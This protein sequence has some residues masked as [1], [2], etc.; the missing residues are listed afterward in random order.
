MTP[1]SERSTLALSQDRRDLVLGNGLVRR[2]IRLSP[3]ATTVS[4]DDLR[5]DRAH[6]RATGA[7]A[8]LRVD[9]V[10]HAVGGLTGQPDRAYLR[11]EW[12][13]QSRPIDGALQFVHWRAVPVEAP[14]SWKRTAGDAE[15]PWPPRGAGMALSFRTPPGAST[16][17][18]VDVHHEI[19]DGIPVLGKWLVVRNTGTRAMRIDGFS[20][21]RL[22]IAE[23]ESIVDHTD[24]WRDPDIVVHSD[25]MFAGK[26]PGNANKVAAWEVDP[27]YQTQVHYERRTPCILHVRPPMGPGVVLAP[28][29]SLRSFRSHLCLHEGTDRESRGLETRR[30]YRTL[31]PWI[32]DN[33]LMLHLTTVEDGAVRRAIDQCVDVGFEMVILSFGSGLNMEDVS[34]A[35][36]AKFRLLA[37]YAHARGIRFGGYSLLASRRIS[38]SDDVIDPKTGTTGG[39]IFGNSPC[40]CSRWGEEYFR[41]VRTFLERTGFDL[42]EHDGSYPGDVCAS[43]KHPGHAGLLDS[44][45]R[46]WERIRDFYAWCRSKGIYL[47]VPDWYFLA[48][49]NKTG[50]GYRETN[51]SLPRREQQVHARRNLYDGTWEKTP[52]MGWMFVPLVEYHGGGGEATIE[53]LDAHRDDYGRVLDIC[54]G[55][56]AQACYRGPRLF[57]TPATRDLVRGKVRWFKQHRRILESDVV[58]VRRA[59][60]RDI[61]GIVHLDQNGSPRAMA[62]FFN[63]TA[64]ELRRTVHLPVGRAGIV[65]KARVSVAGGPSQTVAVGAEGTVTLTVRVP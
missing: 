10:D 20:V 4:L 50:M 32:A 22:A 61:D 13:D 19:Y 40:L 6:L 37:D 14:F 42:L 33:P 17:F 53:P 58:H 57:D 7:E 56:G 24:R 27:E 34:E 65:G 9:G 64:S 12:I 3:A 29:E 23:T 63:P 25:Y 8:W 47:N 28:G 16:P 31:A 2:T 52:S 21:E 51:W 44:Q 62:V 36:L 35:N 46:Q 1:H 5:T 43:T 18:E 38:D 39:A 55:F 26:S 11:P 30:L 60:A 54:L 48:G 49:S 15:A 59:D 45:W 41:K